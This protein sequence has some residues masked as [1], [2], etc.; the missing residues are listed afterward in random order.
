VVAVHLVLLLGT[1]YGLTEWQGLRLYRENCRYPEHSVFRER[2]RFNKVNTAFSI[3]RRG[4]NSQEVADFC[5]LRRSFPFGIKVAR[6]HWCSNPL[7]L[8]LIRICV[9]PMHLST[10][11]CEIPISQ[12]TGPDRA[13]RLAGRTVVPTLCVSGDSWTIR[14]VKSGWLKSGFSKGVSRIASASWRRMLWLQK[15]GGKASLSF[16]FLR[17]SAH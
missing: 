13:G 7:F 11:C 4:R 16:E 14:G 2:Q 15:R 10:N 5:A 1:Q 3:A 6:W 9:E 17:W 8:I 12:V